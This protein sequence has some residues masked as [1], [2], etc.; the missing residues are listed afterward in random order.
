[1]DWNYE[2]DPYFAHSTSG[3]D[4]GTSGKGRNPGHHLGRKGSTFLADLVGRR[5]RVGALVLFAS[6]LVPVL[7]AWGTAKASQADLLG[8]SAW[9]PP[10]LAAV[11]GLGL[12][13]ILTVKFGGWF[14][15]ISFGEEY[16]ET[17]SEGKG[18]LLGWWRFLVQIGAFIAVTTFVAN[19]SSASTLNSLTNAETA[20]L[21][22]YAERAPIPR[23]WELVSDWLRQNEYAST[24]N[25]T[26]DVTYAVPSSYRLP[27]VEEWLKD[28]GWMNGTDGVEPFGEL[29]NIACD[30]QFLECTAEVR[31]PAGEP[32]EYFVKARLKLEALVIQHEDEPIPAG[33]VIF[34][35]VYEEHSPE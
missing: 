22:A 30:K 16:T 17:F 4:Q 8:D 24:P 29:R 7:L 13:L 2:P 25:A 35:T 31:P 18:A 3:S 20:A 21:P 15:L 9:L 11:A 19:A 14:Q 23:D 32:V 1:M 27:D 34:S 12:V 6:Y 26:Y 10:T 28:P 33:A 5:T